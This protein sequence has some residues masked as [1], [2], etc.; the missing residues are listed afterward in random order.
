MYDPTLKGNG[1]KL[2]T[3]LASFLLG[4]LSLAAC[5]GTPVTDSLVSSAPPDL[6]RKVELS[7]T[8][9]F[10]QTQYY[11]GPAALAAAMNATGMDTSPSAIAGQVFTPEREGTLQADVVTAARR[12]GRLAV[13]ISGMADAFTEVA[14]GRPV[15]LLQ[16][17]GLEMAPQW[18]YALLIGFDLE[19]GEAVL[20]SGTT[21]RLVMD[22]E[23][24][25]HTWRRADFWGVAVTS[26]DGPVP[27]TVGPSAWLAEAA[28]LERAGQ[29]AA[30]A[31]AFRTAA[32][33][34]PEASA[35]WLA[36]ANLHYGSGDFAAAENALRTAIAK[37]PGDAAAH[38]NLA[39]VLMERGKLVEAETVALKAV[40]L[41]GANKD[42]AMGT[43]A[44][45]RA[46]S[47]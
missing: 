23:T 18:H 43:L 15:L 1:V 30:A 19:T 22:I 37:D 31:T 10:P 47:S 29:D 38:N 45:I 44:E 42:A 5:A 14:N 25:E 41:G 36:L 20:R 3:R 7:E 28:G 46:K 33:A 11:C 39:H 32:E 4:C 24:L 35:P 26:P 2:A 13:P 16:N 27:A 6:P 8:P 21:R 17:L 9:F 34:W 40:S 12:N